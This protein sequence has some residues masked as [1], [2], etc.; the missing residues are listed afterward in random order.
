MTTRAR[1]LAAIALLLA[2]FGGGVGIGISIDR[3][4]FGRS[5]EPARD[6]D[7]RVRV[8]RIVKRFRSDLRLADAQSDRVAEILRA[9]RARISSIRKRIQPE[10]HA[11]RIKM[12]AE[13]S[14]LLDETQRARYAEM[15]KR[16]DER[17]AAKARR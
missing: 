2:V 4:W 10:V 5:A 8:A 3:A 16:F 15:V 1:G 12:R 14:S 9:G 7:E 17:R 11:E 6:G 13:I